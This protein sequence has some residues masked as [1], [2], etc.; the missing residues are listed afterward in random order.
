M[1]IKGLIGLVVMAMVFGI[2]IVILL[3]MIQLFPVISIIP[4][5]IFGIFRI[6]K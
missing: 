6:K 4:T 3:S 2:P 5:I 1:I